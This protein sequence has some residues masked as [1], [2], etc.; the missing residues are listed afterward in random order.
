MTEIIKPNDFVVRVAASMIAVP[1]DN[2]GLFMAF[3]NYY[4]CCQRMIGTKFDT[5]YPVRA[6]QTKVNTDAI[7]GMAK[8][9]D[10]VRNL[11]EC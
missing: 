8:I 5:N 6:F 11:L 4:K 9:G 3:D 1:C 7:I 2:F 10:G